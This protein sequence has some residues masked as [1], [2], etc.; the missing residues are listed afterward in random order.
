MTMGLI[1]FILRT[2]LAVKCW[3]M[4]IEHLMQWKVNCCYQHVSPACDLVRKQYNPQ[5]G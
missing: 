2:V 1:Y 5:H 4:A 3:K